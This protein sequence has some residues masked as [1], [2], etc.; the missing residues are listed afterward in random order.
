MGSGRG[1][2]DVFGAGLVQPAIS[3]ELSGTPLLRCGVTSLQGWAVFVQL[4]GEQ[5]S[6]EWNAAAQP[7]AA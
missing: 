5:G 3:P 6:D 2:K 4:G 1:R 7:W